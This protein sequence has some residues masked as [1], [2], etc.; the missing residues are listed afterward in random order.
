VLQDE[1]AIAR[2]VAVELK[3][4]LVRD[5]PLQQSLALDERQRRSVSAVK[6]QEVKRVIDE[7]ADLK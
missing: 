6:V 7:P 2:L 1:F 5:K 4:E 3:A